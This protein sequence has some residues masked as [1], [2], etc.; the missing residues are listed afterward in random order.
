MAANVDDANEEMRLC[1]RYGDVEDL[2]RWIDEFGADV[3]SESDNGTTALMMA[4]A[5]GEAGCVEALLQ[6][7]ANPMQRNASGNTALHYATT[8]KQ[9]ECL[10]LLLTENVDVLVKNDFGRSVLTEAIATGDPTIASM[11]LEHSSASEDR[12]LP[13]TQEGEATHE[14][15]FAPSM[16]IVRI[17]ELVVTKS[18]EGTFGTDGDASNDRTGLGVWSSSIVLAKWLAE[19][20]PQFRHRRIVDLGCGCGTAGI[21]LAAAAPT[22]SVHL[23]D[24]CP[25]SLDNCRHNASK[26]DRLSVAHLDWNDTMVQERFDTAIG[27]DLVYCDAVA[28]P[29]A[30]TIAALTDDFWYVSPADGRAGADLFLASLVDLGFTLAFHQDAPPRYSTNAFANQ[31]DDSFFLYFPDLRSTTFVLRRYRRT[32]S[33]DD[34]TV[35]N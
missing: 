6:R 7:H 4:A 33:D 9:S 2:G 12:I 20:A 34:A 1:A 29:L 10:K 11:V 5:N 27:A 19:E 3:D 35:T 21:A 28:G 18:V 25:A 26:G 30:R 15:R 32:P 24:A 14:F 31:D 16:P 23:T 13:S 22:A 8:Q 17:R